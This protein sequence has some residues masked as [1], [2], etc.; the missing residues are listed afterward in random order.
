MMLPA[1]EEDEALARRFLGGLRMLFYAGA[2][3]PP[4]T[5]QRLLAVAQKVRTE[6]LWMTTSWGSTETAPGNTFVNWHI[7]EPGV[8]GLPMPGVSL[9]FVPNGGKLEMRVKGEHIFPGYRHNAEATRAAF[10]EDGYYCI[11]DAG[12]LKQEDDPLQGVVFNGRVAED[13]K[14]TS[15]TWVSVGTLRVRVVS[16]LAPHVQDVVITGHDRSEIGALVFLT[17]AARALP[18][19]QLAQH[20]KQGLHS[21]KADGGGSSQTPT[22]L[23]MLPDGPNAGEGEITDKGYINQRMVLA[24]RA[25][26]VQ[27]LYANSAD[28]TQADP[29]VIRL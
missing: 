23:L 16:A 25:A 6:P 21:L 13:F 26:E 27:A 29:R 5:W 28:D 14:L 4:S 18:A 19:E 7:A 12:Y 2:G 20:L 8:I 11:G 3:M 9:K 24:R 1:L 10:D 17:E 22:R 15:G